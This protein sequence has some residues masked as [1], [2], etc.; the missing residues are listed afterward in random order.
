MHLNGTLLNTPIARLRKGAWFSTLFTAPVFDDVEKSRAAWVLHA[1][2]LCEIIISVVMLTVNLVF[3]RANPIGN[4]LTFGAAALLSLVMLYPLRKGYVRQVGWFVVAGTVLFTGLANVNAVRPFA[5]GTASGFFALMLAGVLLSRR[6]FIWT[7]T[8]LATMVTASGIVWLA[9]RNPPFP[10]E[11]VLFDIATYIAY[12][13]TAG[14]TIYLTMGQLRRA[15][16]DTQRTRAELARRNAILERE[17]VQRKSSESRQQQLTRGLQKIVHLSNRMM[18]AES[19]HDVYAAAVQSACVDLRFER[20]AICLPTPNGEPEWIVCRH[21]PA[22]QTL[23]PAHL[24]IDIAAYQREFESLRPGRAAHGLG[25]RARPVSAAAR[26]L[27]GAPAWVA[28]T[29]VFGTDGKLL[30]VFVTA[31]SDKAAPDPDQ[32]DLLTL[33]CTMFGRI[34]ERKQLEC[35]NARLHQEQLQTAALT[36]RSRIARELHDSV[37]QSLF[38]IVLGVRTIKHNGL[39]ND[40]VSN[41]ALDYVFKLSESAL[42][43][44]RSLVYALRPESLRNEGFLVAFQRQIETLCMR[45]TLHVDI[46]LGTFEPMLDIDAKEAMYRIGLEAVQNAIKHANASR[47]TVTLS[48]SGGEIVL[49]IADNGTG[50][51]PHKRFDGHFGLQTMHERAAMSGAALRIDSV[52]NLG[53]T[54][55]V[56]MRSQETFTDYL[57]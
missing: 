13:V 42:S 52:P 44:M 23:N 12:S 3:I 56:T 54:V 32:Q 28:D 47:I 17:I 55:H 34:A 8:V 39:Q 45:T 38:G 49:S 7:A 22:E 29:P 25:W 30:A 10:R 14:V 40:A 53:T 2:L 19:V 41:D 4:G 11:F 16:D 51:N 31:G 36:E 26:H 24:R 27:P 35:E 33:Y 37:S 15:L 1:W 46:Q 21:C 50:F 57:V 20:S 5:I 43:D 48:E 18:L 9:G 6:E